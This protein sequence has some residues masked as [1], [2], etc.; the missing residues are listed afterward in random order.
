MFPQQSKTKLQEL[1]VDVMTYRGTSFAWKA[2]SPWIS[3]REAFWLEFGEAQ[4]GE[5]YGGEVG[6]GWSRANEVP[7]GGGCL[8]CLLSARGARP[9]Y[10][11]VCV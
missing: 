11:C 1:N 2:Q 6:G 10:E 9:L 7:T 8:K 3:R 5:L 4:A